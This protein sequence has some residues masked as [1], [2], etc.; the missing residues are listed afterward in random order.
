MP[1]NL[2]NGVRFLQLHNPTG[3]PLHSGILGPF[4]PAETRFWYTVVFR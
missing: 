1:K 3:K 2:I 4:A